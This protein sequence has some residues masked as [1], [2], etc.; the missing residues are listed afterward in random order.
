MKNIEKQYTVFKYNLKTARVNLYTL[1]SITYF[2]FYIYF[3]QAI[4]NY[5]YFCFKWFNIN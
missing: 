4:F 1:F 5:Y 2:T 3:H